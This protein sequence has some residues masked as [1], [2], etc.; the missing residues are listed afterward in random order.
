MQ[1]GPFRCH[2]M[3]SRA[4]GWYFWAPR[5]SRLLRFKCVRRGRHYAIEWRHLIIGW[6]R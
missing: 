5:H 3:H 2:W 1:I 6:G 4:N